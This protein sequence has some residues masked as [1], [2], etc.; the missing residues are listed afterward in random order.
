M[1]EPVAPAEAGQTPAPLLEEGDHLRQC[2]ERLDAVAGVVAAPRMRPARVTLLASG[3]EHD[4]IGAPLGPA[5]ALQRNVEG[6]EDFVEGGHRPFLVSGRGAA[7]SGA[8]RS[9]APQTRDPG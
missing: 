7:R 1:V 5:S 9:D 3:A 8:E 6:K 2:V 4:D